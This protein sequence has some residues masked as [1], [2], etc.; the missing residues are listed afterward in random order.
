M[1]I[2]VDFSDYLSYIIN[3]KKTFNKMNTKNCIVDFFH[4]CNLCSNKLQPVA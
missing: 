1:N 2:K 4:C 3:R